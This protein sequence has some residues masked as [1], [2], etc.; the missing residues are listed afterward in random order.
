[1]LESNFSQINFIIRE[2][3]VAMSESLMPN[4]IIK[5]PGWQRWRYCM[6]GHWAP[7]QYCTTNL[8]NFQ[9]GRQ[10]ACHDRGAQG[11]MVQSLFRNYSDINVVFQNIGCQSAWSN[12]QLSSSIDSHIWNL[13][14]GCQYTLL[15]HHPHV[16]C[17]MMIDEY[18]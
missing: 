10:Q 16:E 12:E 15:D 11:D 7:K 18:G 3:T 9:K 5:M 6:L 4:T 14:I 2:K 17:C 1:M 8:A 13:G